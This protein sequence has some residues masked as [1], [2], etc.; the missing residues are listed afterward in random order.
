MNLLD[1]NKTLLVD[2]VGILREAVA[3]VKRKYPFHIDAWV[4]LPDHMHAIW[5]L[6]A[7]DADYSGRWRE[8]KKAFNR[9]IPPAELLSPGRRNIKRDY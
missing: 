4:V 9:C 8:I 6:P 1:R 2:Y 3:V 5:T 7:D